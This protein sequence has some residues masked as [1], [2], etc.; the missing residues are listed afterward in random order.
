MVKETSSIEGLFLDDIIRIL[1]NKS[2]L[3]QN[4][5]YREMKSQVFSYVILVIRFKREMIEDE[6]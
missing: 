4:L 5:V 6:R 1:E 2:V 3:N